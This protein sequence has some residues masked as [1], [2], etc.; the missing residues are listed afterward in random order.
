SFTK[1]KFNVYRKKYIRSGR[2]SAVVGIVRK[3]QKFRFSQNAYLL[4]FGSE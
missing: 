3:I 1:Y 2:D 4:V